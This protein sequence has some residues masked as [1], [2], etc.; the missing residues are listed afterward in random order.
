MAL[1]H[2]EFGQVRL[3]FRQDERGLSVSLASSDPAFARAA[4]AALPIAQ[5]APT[6]ETCTRQGSEGQPRAQAEAQGQGSGAA[7]SRGGNAGGQHERE[8][9]RQPFAAQREA[10]RSADT[11]SQQGIF[12]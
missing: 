6:A 4:S 11:S 2:A 1:P 12:A 9:A 8:G 5:T 3:D 10:R 7:G